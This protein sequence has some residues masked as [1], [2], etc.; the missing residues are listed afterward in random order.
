MVSATWMSIDLIIIFKIVSVLL[1]TCS[2]QVKLTEHYIFSCTATT[3]K[4]KLLNSLEVIDTKLIKLSKE[5]LTKVV[6][7]GFS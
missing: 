5:Q 7:Y 4:I 6:L 2:L 1:C 3:S